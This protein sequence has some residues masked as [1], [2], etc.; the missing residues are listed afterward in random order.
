MKHPNVAHAVSAPPPGE[1]RQGWRI[2]YT[3]PDEDPLVLRSPQM[4]GAVGRRPA[5]RRTSDRIMHARCP[6]YDHVPPAPGCICGVYACANAVDAL[7]R[8]RA[9]AFGMRHAESAQ[10]SRGPVGEAVR[11]AVKGP[12]GMAVLL[13]TEVTCHRPVYHDDRGETPVLTGLEQ[14]PDGVAQ[15]GYEVRCEVDAASRTVY[16]LNEINIPV[17]RAASV[18]ITRIFVPDELIGAAA[19]RTLAQ[20]LSAGYGVE[21]VVGYPD[22]TPDEWDSRPEWMR[23]EP[24]R[25][26]YCVDERL[27]GFTRGGHQPKELCV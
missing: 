15:L 19:A 16:S 6:H 14:H 25:S 20:R 21:A 2:W 13:L 17:I 10:L 11:W 1:A 27:Q 7:Y 5:V 8:L 3:R 26:M 4:R 24:W 22:Y 18:E 12:A 9:M 23:T